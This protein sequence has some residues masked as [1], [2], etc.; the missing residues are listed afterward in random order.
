[1]AVIRREQ[2]IKV[3]N[4]MLRVS[5][6]STLMDEIEKIKKLCRE[7]GFEFNI[8]PDVISAVEKA[9]AEAREVVENEIN[10]Q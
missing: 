10:S 7:N 3:K 2:K 5:I 8:K 4:E 6:P 1:M 9:I